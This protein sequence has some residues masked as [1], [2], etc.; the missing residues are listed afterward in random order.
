MAGALPFLRQGPTSYPAGGYITGGML[1]VAA[2]GLTG[3]LTPL[4]GV[5]VVENTTDGTSTVLGV[6]ASDANTTNYPEGTPS[7]P[8]S[9]SSST[10]DNPLLDSSTLN[11]EV[12]VYNNVDIFV[13]YSGT[14]TLGG[15][16]CADNAGGVRPFVHGTDYPEAVVGRCTNPG[17]VVAGHVGRAF[18]RV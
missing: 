10:D 16:L 4:N 17:G 5:G 14:G 8:S 13:N 15:L 12:A 6:A 1:V 7:L 18:I 2:S 9:A 3:S 11:F